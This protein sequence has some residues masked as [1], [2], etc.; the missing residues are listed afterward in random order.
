MSGQKNTI[1]Y[2]NLVILVILSAAVSYLIFDDRH[3]SNTDNR[4]M[5]KTLA[6]E[7]TD[8]NLH[9]AAIEEYQ[10]ILADNNLDSDKRGNI[11][12]LI[13]KLYYEEINDYENGAA[14]FIRARS[15][16]PE[17]SYYDEAGRSLIA[18]LEKM[19]RIIDAKR[20][21]DRTVNIDSV[22]AEHEGETLVA[23]IGD[24]P[25]FLS[26]IDDEIQK[27]PADMQKEFT[28]KEKKLEAL[29]QYIQL[30]LIHKAALRE[31]LGADPDVI[32]SSDEIIR[33]VMIDKYIRENI[34]PQDQIDSV[35]VYNY[36]LANKENKYNGQ[37]FIQ[38]QQTVLQ[39]YGR[40]KFQSYFSDYIAR[41]AAVEKVQIFEEN[42]R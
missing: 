33:Q 25:V 18:C 21:L 4:E 24:M 6:G 42:I 7:L 31:G 14:Y 30:E 23:K 35:D 41:L 34:I 9:I 26:Q 12:Y 27:L 16:N 40:E 20:E 28:G 8:N 17:G 3:S 39:D 19:G 36:Y 15:I 11:N 29:N 2:I 10:R 5:A 22:Y 13:G 38:V 37:D 1:Q 32:K